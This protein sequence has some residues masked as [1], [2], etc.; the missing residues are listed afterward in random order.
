LTKKGSWIAG[1]LFSYCQISTNCII[2]F[3]LF[4]WFIS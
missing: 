3:T 1:R 2:Y 4:W